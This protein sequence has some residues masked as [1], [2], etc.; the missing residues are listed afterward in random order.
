MIFSRTSIRVEI[1]VKYVTDQLGI[2]HIRID[3]LFI[4]PFN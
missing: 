2:Y 4:F 1:N 3:A